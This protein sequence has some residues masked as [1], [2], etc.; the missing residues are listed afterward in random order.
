MEKES[1]ADTTPDRFESVGN[2]LETVYETIFH[3]TDDAVFLIDVEQ[4]D[5]DGGSDSNGG[6]DYTFTIDR[7]NA[8]HQQQTGR[9]EDE[10]RG[11]PPDAFLGD[12]QA[13]ESIEH[14]RRCVDQREPIVYEETLERPAGTIHWQ[15]KLT[16]L[17]EDGEV[18]GIVGTSRNS[19]ELGTYQ[20]T[21]ERQRDNLEVLNQIVRHDIRNDL[22]LVLAYTETLEEH[23]SEEGEAYARQVI[24]AARDA[25]DITETA[26]DVT[27]VLLRPAVDHSTIGLRYVLED[28]ID[29]IRSSYERAIVTVDSP[30]PD[31]DVL[32]DDM[33]ESVFRNLLTNAIVHNDRDIPEVTVSA[34]ATDDVVE[35]Q[36]ADN[37]PGIP[38]EQ[39]ER[40]FDEG[41]TGLDSEGAGLGLYLVRTLVDRYDGD[42]WVEDN[43]PRGS[44]F[45]VELPRGQ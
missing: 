40:I 19:T 8:A 24:D 35:V 7:T 9:S 29:R 10:L 37:G 20:R 34:T 39:K 27:E 22:Q 43:E 17:I 28:Q 41:E 2:R 13:A 18:T 16:P 45:V 42:V 12:E 31:V 30:I 11:K 6:S 44:V 3:G 36:V 21:L 26:R 33:L 23:V 38:S 14:Y 4:A 5:G 25:V 1:D 32:A 15:T